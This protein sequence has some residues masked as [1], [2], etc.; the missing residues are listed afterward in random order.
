MKISLFV[1][2]GFIFGIGANINFIKEEEPEKI[3]NVHINNISFVNEYRTL[4]YFLQLD[5]YFDQLKQLDAYIDK[6]T[7]ICKQHKKTSNCI[8]F[9]EF[10][11]SNEESMA[12]ELEKIRLYK[13]TWLDR[14]S[15]ENELY[16]FALY[17]ILDQI[18][19]YFAP[20]SQKNIDDLQTIDRENRELT[21]EYIS[22]M[23]N[24]IN[25]QRRVNQLTSDNLKHLE[26]NFIKIHATIENQYLMEVIQIIMGLT[27][28]Q[29][30]F[31]QTIIDMLEENRADKV[32]SMI[33]IED[34]KKHLSYANNT[35]NNHIPKSHTQRIF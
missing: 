33:G 3:L 8:Y 5:T 20:I 1:T 34:L 10:L 2:I 22:I 4:K 19:D 28:E 24:S 18:R 30:R 32:I 12:S 15:R 9:L 23:N 25:V 29:L 7:Q 17:F 13:P 16:H 26:K 21:S 35:L 27:T 11:K 14:Q 31:M 6:T